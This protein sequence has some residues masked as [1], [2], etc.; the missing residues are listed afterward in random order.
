MRVAFAGTPPFAAVALEALL[1]AGHD[2]PLVLCQPDRPSGRGL[3]VV[4]GAVHALARR[5]GLPVHQPLSLKTAEA[6][7]PLREARPEVLVVAA[8]GLLLPQAVLDIP[9]RG[10]L[11]IHGS[12]LPRWR[13][14]APVQR[15]LLAGDAETGVDIM[16]MEAGL[17]TGPVLL[18]RR[19]AIGPRETA[20]ELTARLA[21]L[22]AEAIV[23]ALDQLDQLAARPQDPAA[24]T[25]AAKIAKSEAR[26][27]WALTNQELDRRVR[28][29]NPFPGAEASLDGQPLKV[30]AARPVTGHGEPGV[31]LSAG[32]DG[33][34]VACGSGALALDQ[35]Q[36]SGG[37]RLSVEEFL[38]G[39][40]VQPGTRWADFVAG[41]SQ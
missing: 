21:T 12:L 29:F 32:P 30:W 8:Y 31:V 15:A 7:A 38:K 6:Q 5:H 27:S 13:G 40:P 26:L 2:I 25:Y 37:R 1:E 11:N 9:A 18:E 16:R 35:V 19:T 14:A 3:K 20:G 39:H 36:R 17:D 24:A 33:L 23:A 41:S 34:V 4:P 10:C 22:G 28:A